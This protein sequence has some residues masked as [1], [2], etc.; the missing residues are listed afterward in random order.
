MDKFL[1]VLAEVLDTEAQFTMD[2]VL[3]T[4]EEWDSLSVV[5]FAAMADIEY[6]KKLVAS[7]IK[8]AQTVKDLYNLVAVE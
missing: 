5:S 4:I 7:D 6:G 1:E 2:T 3:K 8:K